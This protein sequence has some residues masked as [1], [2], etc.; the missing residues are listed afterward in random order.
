MEPILLGALPDEILQWRGTAAELAEQCNRL[1]PAIGLTEDA[2]TANERLV[3]HYVQ[4]GVLSP[5]EREGREAVFGVEQI[6]EFLTARHLLRDGWP[7]AKIAEL[8]RSAGPLGL[9]RLV[10]AE[11]APTA[12]ESALA[13]LRTQPSAP[14]ATRTGAARFE[15]PAAS[16]AQ[17]QAASRSQGSA[18]PEQW[19]A[20]SLSMNYAPNASAPEPLRQA[21][22]IAQRRM[23]LHR[24]LVD[25]GN[26]TGKPERRRAVR[27]SLTPWCHVVVDSHELNAMPADTP[28]I[29]GNALTHALHEERLRRGE[30]K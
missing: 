12:A 19:T 23:D 2:G 21:T 25:L 10:S 9:S 18:P 7:L 3:R 5:P 16:L 27:L 11:R 14:R 6:R 26:P 28:E 24:T 15:P 1:L 22:E 4:V 8:V 30:K 20:E 17:P 13:Q 29:L